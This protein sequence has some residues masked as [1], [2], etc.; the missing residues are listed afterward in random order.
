MDV[1][2]A[3]LRIRKPR[4]DEYCCEEIQDLSDLPLSQEICRVVRS[5][6]TN[7]LFALLPHL[8]PQS[9]LQMF[10][11]EAKDAY[12]FFAYCQV[13]AFLKKYPFK[14]TNTKQVAL[15]DFKV[16][17][18]I[19]GLYNRENH[20]AFLAIS[21]KHPDFL[22]VIGEIRLDI[23]KLIGATPDFERIA[24]R[25][26][27]GPGVSL[28]DL[29]KG[30]QTTSYFKWSKLPYSV[31][32]HAKPY[33]KSV[34]ESDPR[35]VGALH[36][37][38]REHNGIEMWRPINMTEFWSYVFREVD[39]SRITTVPKSV[40]TDR[41][42]AIEPLLNVFLQLGV[43]RELRQRLHSRWGYDL[44][45][46][47]KNQ[48]MARAAS[49]SDEFA[50]VDLSAASDL[51]SLK[52]CEMLLPAGWY[53]LLL[54]LRSPVGEVEGI[55]VP[56]EKT[57]S[58]GNGFTFALESLIFGAIVRC[59]IRRTRS[60]RESAVY[61]DD[62]VIPKT[63]Y[64][65]LHTLLNL[66]GFRINENKTFIS[67]PFRESCGVDTF[68]GYNVRPIYLKQKLDN[69]PALLYLHNRFYQM[70]DE[71]EWTW[72]L[73]FKNLLELVRNQIPINI[74]KQFFGPVSED[75]DT[76]LFSSQ[77]LR[78]DVSKGR[79]YWVISPRAVIYN[80]ASDFFFRKLMV[81]LGGSP[82]LSNK[83]DRSHRFN[84]GNAFDITKRG[85]VRYKSTRRSAF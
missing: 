43:D 30:G 46:Q 32:K 77:Y 80:R 5:R 7:Q 81:S 28:G 20:R 14:G 73:D 70:R 39:G 18:E 6:D 74:R 34:I 26:Q 19:C 42:I 51:I 68:L 10:G 12:A 52:I 63:A 22:D 53:N 36:N 37:A 16:N 49:I 75:L 55:V 83:W 15:D 79:N 41:T 8:E 78:Y 58:M 62:I 54:D 2:L 21:D 27:H 11:S 29:Y 67:G 31:T 4:S 9:I 56:Y 38:Y 60:K 72:C 57:S 45:S 24:V 35:W 17:E 66:S 25:A 76:H 47:Q 82:P 85:R 50:T 1:L 69:I 33:A 3:D 71:Y 61:G 48:D 40:K 84:S 44:N 65:Y 23:E 64:A 13:G 59:A